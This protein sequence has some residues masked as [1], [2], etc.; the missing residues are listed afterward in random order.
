V[1]S[2]I[3]GL[4]ALVLLVGSVGCVSDDD[5]SSSGGD[6]QGAADLKH[7]ERQDDLQLKNGSA[8]VQEILPMDG[9]RHYTLA[10]Q[11]GNDSGKPVVIDSVELIGSRGLT[12][13]DDFAVGRPRPYGGMS[14][15]IRYP[16]RRDWPR[17]SEEPLEGVQIAASGADAYWGV[18]AV[19]EITQTEPFAYARVW[20]ITGTLG[21]EPFTDYVYT[22]YAICP[23]ST[24]TAACRRFANQNVPPIDLG[25]RPT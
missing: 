20:R 14:S 10:F 9:R 6:F 4:I 2:G 12:V 25:H 15:D 19:F 7:I 1:T 17:T 3:R 23:T 18:I 21:A 8:G 11:I 13:G 22:G 5:P 24:V 16:P